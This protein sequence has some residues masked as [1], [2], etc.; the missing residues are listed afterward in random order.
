MTY[1]DGDSRLFP[2]PVS[3]NAFRQRKLKDRRRAKGLKRLELWV[4]PEEEKAI[5]DLLQEP[6]TPVG[7]RE[8][9]EVF[10]A[11]FHRMR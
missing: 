4:T 11:V 3:G 2:D 10:R 6:D 9:L 1:Q 8:A 7:I 5:R